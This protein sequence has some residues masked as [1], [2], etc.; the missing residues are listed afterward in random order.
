MTWTQAQKEALARASTNEVLK[1]ALELRHS[2]FASHIRLINH[3]T[4]VD[5]DLEAD[6]PVQPSTTQTFLGTGLRLVEPDLTNQPDPT[7]TIEIDG[8]VGTLFPLI[9]ASAKSGEAILLT[10]RGLMLDVDTSTVAQ[11]LKI[12]HLQFRSAAATMTTISATFGYTNPSNQPFPSQ[13]YDA[14]SNPGLV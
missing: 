7:I 10:L 3:D 1:W 6:A 13:K 12:Y 8:V 4:D 9:R 11:V 2:L 5:V 14:V